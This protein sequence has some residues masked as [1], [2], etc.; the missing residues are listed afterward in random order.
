MNYNEPLAEVSFFDEV[1]GNSNKWE[2][3]IDPD[4]G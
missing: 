2:S 4:V 3:E 1:V